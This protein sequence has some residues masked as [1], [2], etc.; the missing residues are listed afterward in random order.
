M[1]QLFYVY[2]HVVLPIYGRLISKDK[3][4][5]S[6]LRRTIAAFPQGE[7]MMGILKAAGF[8]ETSFKR[9]TA[10]ICTMY[11]ATK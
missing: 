4:A 5:Y 9:L 10:G 6:Y 3:S 1:R 8:K 7:R 11:F 2:S